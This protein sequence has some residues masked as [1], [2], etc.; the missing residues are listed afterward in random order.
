M[1]F[2]ARP[3][4]AAPNGSDP[5]SRA[6]HLILPYPPTVNTYWR[7]VTIKGRGRVLISKRGRA[8]RQEVGLIVMANRLE[9]F[10]YA[11][12]KVRIDACP[13]DNRRRDLDNLPKAVLDALQKAGVYSD[14]SNID[15]LRIVRGSTVKPGHIL[16]DIEAITQKESTHD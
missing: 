1:T 11:K 2:T 10:G 8:Y 3:T 16:V 9:R 14:D 13:P 4:L 12:L 7:M 15:D 5:T 6:V